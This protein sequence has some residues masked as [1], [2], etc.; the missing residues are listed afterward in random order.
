MN[1]K[2]KV[3]IIKIILKYANTAVTSKNANNRMLR[4][5]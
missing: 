1:Q 5:P 3:D 4:H 2:D